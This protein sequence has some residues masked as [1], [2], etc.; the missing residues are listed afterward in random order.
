[1]PL[2]AHKCPLHFLKSRLNGLTWLFA[3]GIRSALH[4][5]ARQL[6]EFGALLSCPDAM[7][8]ASDHKGPFKGL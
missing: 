8:T 2:N 5:A 3:R 7:L 4:G 6:A 1:M